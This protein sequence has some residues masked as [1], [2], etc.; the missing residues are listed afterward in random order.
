MRNNK[1]NIK[2]LF[3]WILSITTFIQMKPYFVWNNYNAA[4]SSILTRGSLFISLIL[5]IFYISTEHRK[6]NGSIFVTIIFLIIVQM[7]ILFIGDDYTDLL[8]IGNYIVLLIII[9]FFFLSNQERIEL[10]DKFTTIFAL[11]LIS[12]I[13]FWCL[14]NLGFQAPFRILQP[15]HAGKA[16]MGAYYKNYFG[17]VFLYYPNSN[18]TRLNAM[19]DEPG[20]VGTFSALLLVANDLRLKGKLKNIIILIGGI[21]SFSMAFYVLVPIAMIV[22]SFTKRSFKLATLLLIGL[23][24]FQGLMSIQTD[25]IIVRNF[26]QNRFKIVDGNIAGDNRTNESFNYEYSEFLHGNIN[27]V[28]FGNGNNAALNNPAMNESYTYKML[29][30]DFGIIGF[31][32]IVGWIFYASYYTMKFEKGCMV[33]LI[34]FIISMYQRPYV[35]NMPY[36]ILLFCGYTN[37]KNIGNIYDNDK[38]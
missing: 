33:L 26:F 24:L 29:I 38:N 6:I 14:I 30:Y 7:Y 17:S 8:S 31:M 2:S 20:V 13:I 12:A 15:E 4:L 16:A 25:N 27:K 18:L 10:L 35:L 36:M 37:I 22:K 34:T 32:M 5:I 23:L 1:I 19:F 21:L 28:L 3:L 11:S 9:C